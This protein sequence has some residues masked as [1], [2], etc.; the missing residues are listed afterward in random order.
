MVPIVELTTMGCVTKPIVSMPCVTTSL[1][2]MGT[3]TRLLE[4]ET[5][6]PDEY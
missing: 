5:F 3:W 2:L 6:F 1:E 4:R